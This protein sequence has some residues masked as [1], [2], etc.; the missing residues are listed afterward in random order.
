M[1]LSDSAGIPV[2]TPVILMIWMLRHLCWATMVASSLMSTL[3]FTTIKPRPM[4]QCSQV[5]M[6]SPVETATEE[7]TR[8]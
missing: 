8:N 4:V 7:M 2:E 1:S 3:F 6:T 5:E